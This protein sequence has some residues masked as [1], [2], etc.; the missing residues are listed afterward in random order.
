[1]FGILSGWLGDRATQMT[2]RSGSTG[3]SLILVAA[4]VHACVLSVSD[5]NS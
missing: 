1:M 2:I 5:Y 3:F 4:S